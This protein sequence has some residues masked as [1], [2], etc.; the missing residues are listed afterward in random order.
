MKKVTEL[1]E[2]N[3]RLKATVEAYAKQVNRLEQ[4]LLKYEKTHDGK[5]LD[6]SI[7]ISDKVSLF[8]FKTKWW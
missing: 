4:R 3:K 5:F 1:E 2:E 7:T 6:K 8:D